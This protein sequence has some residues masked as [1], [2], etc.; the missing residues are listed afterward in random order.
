MNQ[1]IEE[2]NA[3]SA[4]KQLAA[5][6][7]FTLK[8]LKFWLPIICAVTFVAGMWLGVY[9]KSLDRSEPGEK[10]L[11]ELLELIHRNYVDPVE[12]DSL[13]EMAIPA[14]LSNLDPHSVY[15]A[16]KDLEEANAPLKGS[17]GGIGIQFQIYRDTINVVEVMAEGP[18]EKAGLM[19]GDRIV[20]VDGASVTG[21]YVTDDK[22]REK[23][24]GPQGSKVV[25]TIVRPGFQ[26]KQ[27]YTLIRGNIPLQSVDT[28]YMLSDKTGMVKV[29]SFGEHTYAEFMQALASLKSDGAESFIIDLRGNTGGYMETA[30]LMANEFLEPG[31]TIVSTRGRSFPDDIVLSDGTGAF[32]DA[33]LV[34]LIDEM[35]ASSSEIFAGAMQDHDR[36]LIIG[37]RS[38]GK[39]LVQRPITFDDGSELRLTVQRYYTPSGRSIQKEYKPGSKDDY[40][41]EIFERFRNGEAMKLDSTKLRKD[42]MFETSTGR[43]VYGG[44]G[45]FPDIFVPNDTSG[46]TSY[47]MDVANKGLLM[48][49][50][51]EYCDLNRASLGKVKTVEELLRQL[52]P[53]DTLLSSFVYYA[54]TQG[55]KA[56]WY[57]I[58]LS[59]KLI[60]NQLKAYIARDVLGIPAFYRIWQTDDTAVDEALR[61]IKAGKASFP[62]KPE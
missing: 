36:A 9:L 28:Y 38:F 41:L 30:I 6:H 39:G 33:Q 1:D 23:L 45:I 53:D 56:R 34:V 25:L 13:V 2:K 42:L 46:V 27:K 20:A 59:R 16:A 18:A 40:E 51:Y 55:V 12:M 57:Y 24:R 37:R 47:Y 14:L 35:S 11:R 8:R 44:G 21:K 43:Q 3:G 26:K 7:R 54:T 50:A 32:T 5:E 62:I 10:K 48:K 17:F 29:S 58:K 52:P 60:V 19:A 31:K 15:I 61:Q 4:E 49:F 22:V